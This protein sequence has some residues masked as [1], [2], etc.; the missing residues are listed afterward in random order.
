M[1]SNTFGS[2]E[3]RYRNFQYLDPLKN[4]PNAPDHY[5]KSPSSAVKNEEIQR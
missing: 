4:N 5:G 1:D 3:W 2:K